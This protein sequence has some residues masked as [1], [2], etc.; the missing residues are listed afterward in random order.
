MAWVAQQGRRHITALLVLLANA[1]SLREA[2]ASVWDTK[3]EGKS[4]HIRSCFDEDA[5]C[6][7]P[8]SQAFTAPARDEVKRH[9][10]LGQSRRGLYERLTIVS[11]LKDY[12]LLKCG[13]V[14]SMRRTHLVLSS[15]SHFVYKVSNAETHHQS[16]VYVVAVCKL[17]TSTVLDNGLRYC[18]VVLVRRR[19]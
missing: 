15:A 9:L 2:K 16:L 11:R 17:F 8:F 3:F 4:A 10:A 1:A 7:R 5:F 18:D 12:V 19:N 6:E 13:L 14:N